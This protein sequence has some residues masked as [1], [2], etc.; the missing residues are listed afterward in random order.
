[1]TIPAGAPKAVGLAADEFAKYWKLVTGRDFAEETNAVA[2]FGI[3]PALDAA[4][5]EYR[6]RSVADGVEFIGSNGRSVFFAVYDFLER[7]AGC[8]WFWDGDVV[9]R[10]DTIDL[11]GLDVREKSRFEY[12][13]IRYFAHRGLT[14]FQAE[15]WGRKEWRQEIDWCLKSRL[16]CF[17]PRIG[18]DDTWQKAFPD[19]VGYPAPDDPADDNMDG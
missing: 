8:R 2:H 10:R 14:R 5:D 13:A 7:R 15:H 11:G 9:P 4:H 18:M 3:D 17:M 19:I 6:I 1:M 16:N 12:R